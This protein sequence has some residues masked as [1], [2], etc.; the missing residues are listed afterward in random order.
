MTASVLLAGCDTDQVSLATNAKANQPVPPKLVAAMAEKDMDLQ[1]P[2]LVRLFKQE[3]EL[4]VWKQTRSGQFALLKTYP[5]CR[6][7]GDLGPKV[8]EGDR[9]APE[10]FYSINPSQMN[11]QS[12]YYLSFN[13]GFPNAFDKALGRTGSQLMV[14]GD[15]SSRGC[16]AMTDEQIAE[17]YSLGRES[18]FGGQKAFQLQ[19]YPFKMTPVN[20]AKHR[21]NPN[22]PFWKMIKEGYDHFE[23]TRQE[24]KVDFCEKRYVFDAA[25]S[26]DAKRD[27]VFDASAKCPAYVIPEDIASAV[28]EKQAKDEAEYA[29]L[30]AKGTPMARMNTGIDGGMNKIFA[31]KIPEGSTG[32]SEEAEG[33]TLQLLAMSKAPGTIPGHVNPPKPNLDAVAAAPAQEP[34]VAVS[35]PV[36]NTRVASAQPAEKP[37]EKSQEKSEGGGFFSGLGRKMGFSTADTTATTPPPQAAAAAAPATTTTTPSSAASRLKAAV[38]RFVPGHDKSKDAAKDAPKPAVAAAKPAEPPKPQQ[39]DTRLAQ[40]RPALKPSVSDGASDST[41]MAGAAPVVSSNSFESRFGAVK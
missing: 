35:A 21:N 38:T 1:S 19:A 26:A 2:I 22:M 36:A 31:A 39:P 29:K 18:F 33:S 7:S 15:C 11:P 12:A 20:M 10:G 6:W 41:Q 25:K 28:R 14:H 23:V 32:L 9:Q 4:E 8:R 37:Q 5:I 13:T 30:V 27:P 3:A 16:Y 17:I 40:T 34:A 24:P